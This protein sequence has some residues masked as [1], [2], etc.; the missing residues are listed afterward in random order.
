MKR[1]VAWGLMRLPAA[2]LVGL[3]GLFLGLSAMAMNSHILET[4]L[5]PWILLGSYVFAPAMG[6]AYGREF[7]LDWGRATAILPIAANVRVMSV[8]WRVVAVPTLLLWL[9]NLVYPLLSRVDFLTWDT[10]AQ[11]IALPFAGSAFWFL[12]TASSCAGY[13]THRGLK[14]EARGRLQFLRYLVFP[15]FPIALVILSDLEQ[16]RIQIAMVFLLLGVVFSALGL[17]RLYA[18]SLADKEESARL[19]PAI[20]QMVS[21]RGPGKRKPFVVDL[22]QRSV[23]FALLTNVIFYLPLKMLVSLQDVPAESLGIVLFKALPAG[24]LLVFIGFLSPQLSFLRA[25]RTLPLDAGRISLRVTVLITSVLLLA[26]I[27]TAFTVLLLF[28]SQFFARTILFCIGAAGITSCAFVPLLLYLGP[29]PSLQGQ[30]LAQAPALV[31]L[32]LWVVSSQ[33]FFPGN[34]TFIAPVLAATG[35]ALTFKWI[36]GLILRS[37]RP[38][39]TSAYPTAPEV[40][41]QS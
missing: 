18:L 24:V 40:P 33:F 41:G 39:R 4:S 5:Y 34:W 32:A 29:N 23:L 8:W 13:W 7:S 15:V 19:R 16:D 2:A 3:P 27:L 36:R 38:Y 35:V 37:S 10:A 20:N 14:P 25:M 12:L 26:S 30:F 22:L 11:G 17:K 21:R 28:G 9:V 6:R 1:P 31:A